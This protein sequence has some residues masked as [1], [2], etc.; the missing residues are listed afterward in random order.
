MSPLGSSAAQN[1]QIWMASASIGIEPPSAQTGGYRASCDTRA[2]TVC[3]KHQGLVQARQ[4]VRLA[5]PSPPQ[6]ARRTSPRHHEY[7]SAIT[8]RPIRL[9]D[10]HLE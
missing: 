6:P 7:R 9:P 4:G 5:N 10:I 8:V 2:F 1:V 3:N